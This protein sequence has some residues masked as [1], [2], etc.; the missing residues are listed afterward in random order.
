MKRMVVLAAVLSAACGAGTGE[1]V[2]YSDPSP[3][4]KTAA[5]ADGVGKRCTTGADCAGG[6][7]CTD[8]LSAYHDRECEMSVQTASCP[9]GFELTTAYTAHPGQSLDEATN[10]G[11]LCIR[12]CATGVDCNNGQCC[13]AGWC[14]YNDPRNFGNN[15]LD[16]AE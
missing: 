9:I 10:H 8:I 11:F 6:L 12:G 4:P 2:F 1:Y 15:P 5:M 3:N 16:C 14:R 13:L 7:T